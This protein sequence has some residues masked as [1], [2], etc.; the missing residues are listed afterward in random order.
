LFF[1]FLAADFLAEPPGDFFAVLPD[2]D[3]DFFDFSAE[4]FFDLLPF[5]A[6]AD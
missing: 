5:L 3:F 2:L 4:A 6:A 1:A